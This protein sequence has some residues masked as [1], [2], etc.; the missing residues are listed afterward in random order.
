MCQ[1]HPTI[2]PYLKSK[3]FENLSPS[4]TT[5]VGAIYADTVSINGPEA[6]WNFPKW[7]ADDQLMPGV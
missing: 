1:K 6:R 5:K 3:E 7:K 4:V 2:S